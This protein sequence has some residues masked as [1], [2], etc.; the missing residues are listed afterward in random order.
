MVD[1]CEI[2]TSYNSS[3]NKNYTTVIR[4]NSAGLGDDWSPVVLET[5][6]ELD[7]AL[8]ELLPSC[9]TYHIGGSTNAPT[10]SIFL[11]LSQIFPDDKGISVANNHLKSAEPESVVV[12]EFP[13]RGANP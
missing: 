12:S 11:G 7:H 8:D 5:S 2:N 13:I 10:L 4:F 1:L 6:V 3:Y 9:H